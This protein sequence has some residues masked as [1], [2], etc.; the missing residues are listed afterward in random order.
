MTGTGTSPTTLAITSYPT[1]PAATQT[2][3][4]TATLQATGGKS[5][6]TWQITAGKLQGLTFSPS[7]GSFS[8]TVAGSV[9]T[10]MYNITV[11]VRDSS[12]P[13]VKASTTVTIPVGAPTKANCNITSIEVTGTQTPVVALNDLG[14]GT[15]Q[16]EEGGLYPNGSNVNPQQAGGESQALLIQPLDTNGN[17]SPTGIIGMISIGE[18]A[19]QQPFSQFIPIAN[20]DP[21][22]NPAIVIVNGAL[23]GETAGRLV[24]TDN[25]FINTIL[26]Y[27]LPFGGVGPGGVATSVATKQVQ[28]A[29]VDAIDSDQS[30]FP[31][32]AQLLQ[33]QIESLAQIL[34]T[35]FP[36][37]KIA[38]FG[39]LNYTGYSQ[40][41]SQ[42]NPEPDSYET[43]F[44][45]KWAI[46]DQ[47]NGLSTLNW[48]PANGTVVAPW[49]G[50]GDYYWANG[51][52]LR[53]DGTY[54]SC[55]DL[56]KD[57]V[58]PIYPGGQLKIAEGLLSFV[59]SDTT[60]TPWFLVP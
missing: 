20:A 1:L 7:T 18:S 52:L 14:T 31:G 29:W 27:L 55:Q 34:Y 4:Y 12:S 10:G 42:I 16:G 38:Y 21:S 47:V 35:T 43:G 57:G 25:G 15:Y 22:K 56:N 5:P 36:N 3:P 32:D 50:W 33:G 39:S 8:G 54:W 48:N 9:G 51:L 49:M 41:V 58:H 37:L 40:G 23:G 45:D 53:Q 24:T 11:Q 28:V 30:G 46:Q 19:T 59:K 26:N 13:P 60:A 6:Y 44:G 17:P 2:F